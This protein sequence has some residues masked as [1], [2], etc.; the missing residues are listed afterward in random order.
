[1]SNNNDNEAFEEAITLIMQT[2]DVVITPEADDSP[3]S[4]GNWLFSVG[5]WANHEVKDIEM[6]GV[7]ASFVNTAGRTINEMNAYRLLNP[8]NPMLVE[9]RIS[10]ECGYFEVQDSEAHDGGVHSW[11]EEEM[12]RIMPQSDMHLGC[13]CCD[14]AN[15]GIEP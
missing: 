15:A 13:A 10:W 11:K 7:P 9:H 3:F 2:T 6:R 8:S 14:A 5:M 12:L 1:M 4:G